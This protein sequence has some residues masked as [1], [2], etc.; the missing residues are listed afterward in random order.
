MNEPKRRRSDRVQLTIPLRMKGSDDAGLPFE[1]PVH[2]TSLNRHGARIYSTRPLSPGQL[3]RLVNPLRRGEAEFRVV[4]PVSPPLEQG[5]EWGVECGNPD[6]NVWGI[7]FPQRI[8]ESDAKALLECHM[9]HEVAITRLSLVEVDVLETSGI[10]SRPCKQCAANTPW[11]YPEKQLAM[12]APP[13][14][15]AV[16]DSAQAGVTPRRERREHRRIPLQLPVRIRDYHGGVE[17]TTTEDVSKSGFGYV[18]EKNYYVGEGMLTVCPYSTSGQSIES[19]SVIVRAHL[20]PGSARKT[21]G[22]RYRTTS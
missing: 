2:T 12:G 1:I 13:D 18:S 15:Y 16:L 5:G 4:G 19:S 3:V 22:V 9:C 10:L 21:Y 7:N 8:E 14:E 6:A 11:G 20:I 17:V